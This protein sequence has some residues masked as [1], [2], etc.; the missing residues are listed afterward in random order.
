M[1][2]YT[3]LWWANAAATVAMFLVAYI[4]AVNSDR[5]EKKFTLSLIALACLLELVYQALAFGRASNWVDQ[6]LYIAVTGQVQRLFLKLPL[7]AYVVL[8]SRS[9]K[10]WL[11]FCRYRR[12]VFF[13]PQAT[14][15]APSIRRVIASKA[16]LR[17]VMVQ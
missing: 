14:P 11:G 8:T 1:L 7:M 17:E 2:L 4:A 13:L 3:W 16:P 5:V 10:A 6:A 9:V 12:K 15:H